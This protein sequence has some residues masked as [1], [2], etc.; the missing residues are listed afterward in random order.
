M[1]QIPRFTRT[2]LPDRSTGG[3]GIELARAPGEQRAALYRQGGQALAGVT[4][5]QIRKETMQAKADNATW[6]NAQ[7]SE[8]RKTLYD[9]MHEMRKSRESSPMNFHKDFDEKMAGMADAF[10]G[11]APSEAAQ[12]SIR[13]TMTDMRTSFYDDN[14]NWVESRNVSIFGERMEKT[15]DNM[16]SIAY[17]EGLAGRPLDSAGLSGDIEAS[18]VTGASFVAP[19]KLGGIRKAMKKGV[20]QD[21]LQ[22]LADAHP[23]AAI[24]ALDSPEAMAAF[25]P[26]EHAKLKASLENRA[27]RVQEINGQKEVLGILKDESGLLSRSLVE[28]MSYGDLQK[29]F[30]RQPGMS[31]AAKEYFMKANGFEP[32]GEQ[33]LAPGEKMQAKAEIYERLATMTAGQESWGITNAIKGVDKMELT[34]KAIATFQDTVFTAMNNKVLTDDEGMMMLSQVLEPF[35]DQNAKALETYSDN[36]M[37]DSNIGLDGVQ[38]VFNDK[39]ALPVPEEPN[40]KAPAYAKYEYNQA[41]AV[42]AANRVKLYDYY[43]AALGTAAGERGLRVGDIP[44]LNAPQKRKIYAEAQGEAERL[45]MLDRHPSLATLKDIPNQVF[46]AGKLIQGAAGPRDIKPD[47]AAK[48]KFQILTKDGHKARRYEDGSIEVIE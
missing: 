27:L 12:D 25:E 34:P 28:P 26:E 45:Y 5:M 3:A 37:F 33:K 2:V 9:N 35:A 13:E 15:A 31:A 6:V 32:G 30:D 46:S 4:D 16:R 1:G 19:E 29:E 44:T 20:M 8:Y 14:L 43:M 39:I 21:Y 17:Q 41:K 24:K 40:E 36:P 38:K 18:V 42:N 48:G 10:I 23:V 22:G 11:S 7:A 47:G